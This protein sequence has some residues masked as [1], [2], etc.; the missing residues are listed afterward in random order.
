[1]PDGG[2]TNE[3]G[4]IE[5]TRTALGLCIAAALLAST[6]EAN[7]PAASIDTSTGQPA[8]VLKAGH[9]MSPI[10]AS[11]KAQ[12]AERLSLTQSILERIAPE[13]K[14]LG[15]SG[16][17]RSS[18]SNQL[19]ALPVAQL[20]SVAVVGGYAATLDAVRKPTAT[21]QKA[22]GDANQDLVYRPVTPC[23][24]IDTRNVG[25]KISGSRTFD[26]DAASEAYGGDVGCRPYAMFGGGLLALSMNFTILDPG[27]APG[28]LRAKP[29][30]ST[31][32]TS[33]VNWYAVGPSVQ[34][35]NAGIVTNDNGAAAEELQVDTSSSVHV[36]ADIFGG[37]VRATENASALEC[38]TGDS[39]SVS[40]P[41]FSDG[42]VTGSA[43]AVGYSLT[44]ISCHWG[45]SA[46][47]GP[48]F[49][50]VLNVNGTDGR[51]RAHNA[52]ASAQNLYIRNKCCR[53]PAY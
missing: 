24:Y 12:I 46:N 5:M 31:S 29:F 49:T 1:L 38:T 8:G 11:E 4:E 44:G 48:L 27:G 52:T 47:N 22:L 37:F 28:F 45:G 17:W 53:V 33:L 36:I 51:C 15:L 10:T 14:A 41:A 50:F 9:V 25:G 6:V 19:L 23:R 34:V 26:Y 32:A 3:L 42:D 18:M 39:G 16:G 20:R 43:C 7:G 35:G 30:G 13:A 40:V 21:M 2:F